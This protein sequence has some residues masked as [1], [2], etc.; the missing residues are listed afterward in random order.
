MRNLSWVMAC[1]VVSAPITAFAQ[2]AEQTA[3]ASVSAVSMPVL[4]AG[5]PVIVALDEFLTSKTAR[6]GDTFKIS[7]TEDVRE[8]GVLAI[9][10]GTTGHGEVTFSADNGAFGSAGILG[11]AVRS[12]DLDGRTVVLDGRY[13]QEGQSKG[14]AAAITM[15]AVGIFAGFVRGKS[16]IIPEGRILRAR[17][18][19]D[20][21]LGPAVPPASGTP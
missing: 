4:H 15:F 3:G 13:R 14:D 7:V 18:G 10:K 8:Q 17:I 6:V 19:E 21:A 16:S 20:F 1:A 11:I 5:T 12:L 2:N 9:P